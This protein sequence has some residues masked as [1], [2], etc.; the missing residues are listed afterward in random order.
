M[1]FLGKK[2][3]EAKELVVSSKQ[4]LEQ[5]QESIDSC[6]AR[7]TELLADRKNTLFPDAFMEIKKFDELYLGV[8][9]A[10]FSGSDI[11]YTEIKQDTTV[12]KFYETVEQV[13]PLKIKEF[14]SAI[15]SSVVWGIIVSLLATGALLYVVA[16]IKNIAFDLTNIADLTQ[17]KE[18]CGAIGSFFVADN[19]VLVGVVA[20]SSVMIV[21]TVVVALL[22]YLKRASKNIVEAKS[23]SSEAHLKHSELS[24]QKRKREAL[25][26]YLEAQH[27]DISCL[28]VFLDEY[29]S[30]MRRIIFVEGEDYQSY[31]E[32]SKSDIRTCVEL[33]RALKSL[34]NIK[35]VTS[36]AQIDPAAKVELNSAHSL[37]T[38]MMAPY[39]M[40]KK[41]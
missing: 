8:K 3:I 23:I 19:T 41:S 29:N 9:N 37:T 32:S 39:A 5:E 16:K 1:S 22:L 31:Q 38:K 25:V 12:E 20:L 11:T 35:I 15:V 6:D 21:P 33:Y 10:L 2:N 24:T 4:M 27:R 30:K 18:L 17:L 36:N 26:E 7:V 28:S 13:E 40:I 14:N 34:L